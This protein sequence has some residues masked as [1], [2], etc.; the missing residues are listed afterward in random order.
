MQTFLLIFFNLSKLEFKFDRIVR[1]GKQVT[2]GFFC[3]LKALAKTGLSIV[4]VWCQSE[5]DLDNFSNNLA[6]LPTQWY[7]VYNCKELDKMSLPSC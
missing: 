1:V 2:W 4:A 7:R 5:A 3:A 6:T